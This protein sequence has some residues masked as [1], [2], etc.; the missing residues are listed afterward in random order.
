MTNVARV[1]VHTVRTE[2]GENYT[3]Y[4]LADISNSSVEAVEAALKG[5]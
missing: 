3:V 5:R 2:S 4:G 1:T